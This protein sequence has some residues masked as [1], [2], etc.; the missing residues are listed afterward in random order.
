MLPPARFSRRSAIARGL[1]F[2][3]A[4]GSLPL[5][6][7]GGANEL[8]VIPSTKSKDELQKEIENPYGLSF[9]QSSK[10]RGRRRSER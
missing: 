3:I 6:G 7:C 1:L 9:K 8:P 4:A 10:R 5:A 2:G